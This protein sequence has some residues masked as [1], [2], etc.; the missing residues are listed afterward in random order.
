MRVLVLGASGMLGSA[1]FR[2]FSISPGYEVFGSLRSSSVLRFFPKILQPLLS[3]IGDIEDLAE[4][5]KLIAEVKPEVVINCIGLVKHLV[6]DKEPLQAIDVNAAFPHRLASLC[7]QYSCRLIHMGTDC[8]FSGEKGMYTE[9]DKSDASDLYGRSKYLG[10]VDCLHAITLRTSI[11]GHE[12][13]SSSSLIDWFLTQET[14]I[15]GYKKA[16]FSG[17]P[18][19][20]LARIIRDYV[21]PHPHLRGVYNVSAVAITKYD[22]LSLVANVYNKKIEIYPDDQV[23]INRSLD[24][25]KFCAATGYVAPSWSEL[26]QLMHANK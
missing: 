25:S 14:S 10:E 23:N 18:T 15:K 8:V 9:L 22:L 24:S 11:I 7:E 1:I 17:L 6:N 26:I 4:V 20:E 2:F 19:V 16:I 3:V 12:L 13:N 5:N 21:I